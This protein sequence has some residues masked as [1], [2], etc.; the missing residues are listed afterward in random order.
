M[1]KTLFVL[2]IVLRSPST[3]GALDEGIAA[4]CRQTGLLRVPLLQ[5]QS[6]DHHQVVA[7]H[8]FYRRDAVFNVEPQPAVGYSGCV[9]GRARDRAQLSF[10]ASSQELGHTSVPER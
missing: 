10:L 4:Y 6:D 2:L 7:P 5:P 3:A 8:A 9:L 1:R